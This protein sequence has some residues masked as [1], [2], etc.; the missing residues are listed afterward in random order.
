MWT[1]TAHLIC[2]IGRAYGLQLGLEGSVMLGTCLARPGLIEWADT[3]L[4]GRRIWR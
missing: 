3:R 1:V 4:V 2:R